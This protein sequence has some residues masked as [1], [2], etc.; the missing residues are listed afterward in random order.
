MQEIFSKIRFI[1]KL[2]AAGLLSDNQGTKLLNIALNNEFGN[3]AQKSADMPNINNNFF[4]SQSRQ[5]LKNFFQENFKLGGN[6]DEN[7]F[8]DLIKKIEEQ[9]INGYE[10]QKNFSQTL[11]RSNNAAKEKLTSQVQNTAPSNETATKIYTRAEIDKMSLEDYQK[12]EKEIF[13]QVEQGLIH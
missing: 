3:N 10:Q 12:N 8:V 1:E 7:T 13:E 6:F 4:N 5:N 9:A 11:E 2:H